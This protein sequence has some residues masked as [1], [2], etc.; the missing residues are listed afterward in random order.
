MTTGDLRSLTPTSFQRGNVPTDAAADLAAQVLVLDLQE[1]YP[2]IQRLRDWTLSSLAPQPGETAVDIGCGTGAEVRRL[3]A[4]VGPSG[5]AVGVEPHPGLR[6]EAEARALAEG[7]TAEFVEGEALALPFGDGSVDV[8]RCERV[9][10][11]LADPLGAT[12]EIARVLAPGG[13]VAL[14]DSDWGS[15]VQ[16]MGEPDVVRRLMD[17]TWSNWANPFVG[18]SLRWLLRQAGL[19]VDD[20]IG[21]DAAVL[22]DA[23]L[24]DPVLLRNGIGRAIADGSITAEEGDQLERDNLAGAERGEAFVAITMFSVV[25]RSVDPAR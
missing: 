18:R 19:V 2:G 22:P 21:A 1:L 10:Q 8:V 11:H 3:A 12:R 24:R 9:F 7:S 4:L 13:R 16:S 15:M 23:M 25:G 6:A 20:E 14:V 5:R 17:S